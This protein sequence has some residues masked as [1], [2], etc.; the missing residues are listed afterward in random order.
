MSLELPE[1][2]RGDIAR[3][4]L[5]V[6]DGGIEAVDVALT[7]FLHRVD[8]RVEVLENQAIG[9]EL[10][11]GVLRLTLPKRVELKPRKIEVSV[12]N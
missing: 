11:D 4:V 9:A 5:A 7:L 8:E 1:V 12:T 3:H 10:K 6:E 2:V